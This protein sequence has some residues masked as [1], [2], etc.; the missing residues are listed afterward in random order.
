MLSSSFPLIKNAT[1]NGQ[2]S[3]S[4]HEICSKFLILHHIESG[5]GDCELDQHLSAFMNDVWNRIKCRIEPAD[6]DFYEL[7]ICI[8]T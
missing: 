2:V 6:Y 8:I 1:I 4:Y 7:T 5:R 3:Y